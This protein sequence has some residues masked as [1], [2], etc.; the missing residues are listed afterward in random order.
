L[1]T[2]TCSPFPR[3]CD[4]C[5][6]FATPNTTISLATRF[7]LAK[8][9]TVHCCRLKRIGACECSNKQ[10]QQ[11]S[12]CR[13]ECEGATT[14]KK[15]EKQKLNWIA[16]KHLFFKGHMSARVLC[17][18]LEWC[19][20]KIKVNALGSEERDKIS[21]QPAHDWRII[22]FDHVMKQ[23]MKKR[24]K[25]FLAFLLRK[26]VNCEKKYIASR[27]DLSCHQYEQW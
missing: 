14:K 8:I 26:A 12:H 2:W 4:T 10:Q 11:H 15:K 7:R 9:R 3:S 24:A 5:A 1:V 22:F 16:R 25:F 20:N 6:E 18:A 13:N 17:C 23:S 27:F 21:N 19:V